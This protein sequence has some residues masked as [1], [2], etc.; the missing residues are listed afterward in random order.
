MEVQ[1]FQKGK[2]I[3]NFSDSYGYESCIYLGRKDHLQKRG[4]E[5]AHLLGWSN[6]PFL[7]GHFCL[8]ESGPSPLNRPIEREAS[9]T[10]LWPEASSDLS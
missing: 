8:L 5:V 1:N 9:L 2:Q 7:T 6:G 3:R 4:I 10:L